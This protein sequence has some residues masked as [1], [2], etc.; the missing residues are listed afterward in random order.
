MNPFAIDWK[1]REAVIA[2]AETFG[3]GQTVFKH[4]KRDNWSIT[5]TSTFNAN[6][7]KYDP[8]WIVHQ[9]NEPKQTRLAV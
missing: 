7:N 1:D 4:P 9:T 6:P 2:Y 5:H 8:S 3:P